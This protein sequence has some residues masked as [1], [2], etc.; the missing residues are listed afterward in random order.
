MKNFISTK[1]AYEK[2]FCTEYKS[3]YSFYVFFFR[4]GKEKFNKINKNGNNYIDEKEIK[5]YLK[6]KR[7]NNL[8]KI[9]YLDLLEDISIENNLYKASEILG[10]KYQSHLYVVLRESS[11]GTKT[12]KRIKKHYKELLVLANPSLLENKVS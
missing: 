12:I 4:K 3:Y 2:Y 10:Y 8:R 11:I 9:K 5:R 1:H 7:I 6:R